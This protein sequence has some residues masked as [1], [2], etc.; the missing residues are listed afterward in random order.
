MLILDT[1]VSAFIAEDITGNY[2]G[3]VGNNYAYMNDLESKL[4]FGP[5][6][7]FDLAWGEKDM[8]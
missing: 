5:L 4:F 1:A 8:A 3:C 7:D 2:D 6:W